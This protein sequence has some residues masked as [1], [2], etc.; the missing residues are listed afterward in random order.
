MKSF[1]NITVLVVLYTILS[2][3]PAQA[4]NL[5]FDRGRHPNGMEEFFMIMAA[6]TGNPDFCQKISHLAQIRRPEARLGYQVISWKSACDIHLAIQ[7]NKPELCQSVL[8]TRASGLSGYHFNAKYCEERVQAGYTPGGGA[9]HFLGRDIYNTRLLNAENL[10]RNLG[11]TEKDLVLQTNQTEYILDH[12]QKSWLSFMNENIQNVK[13]SQNAPETQRFLQRALHLKDLRI[14]EN[15]SDML[16]RFSGVSELHKPDACFANPETEFTC[17]MIE[18]MQSNDYLTCQGR[19]DD[20]ENI[21][22]RDALF[23]ECVIKKDETEGTC[24]E[25]VSDVYEKVFSWSR[26]QFAKYL[27]TPQKEKIKKE[28]STTVPDIFQAVDK[29]D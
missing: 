26:E 5:N 7:L 16:L 23:Q 24:K 1:K 11:Y 20:K 27:V 12:H 13:T 4:E 19:K 17:R 15:N 14:E 3:F 25:K 6:E 2:I 18:C 8:R 9:T 21:D 28:E 22:L 29:K 10:M